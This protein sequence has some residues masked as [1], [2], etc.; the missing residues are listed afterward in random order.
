MAFIESISTLDRQPKDLGFDR[1][2]VFFSKYDKLPYFRPDRLA[3]ARC[4]LVCSPNNFL[5]EKKGEKK[6][7]SPIIGS[8]PEGA[9]QKLD[10]S[11]FSPAEVEDGTVRTAI[12]ANFKHW[13]TLEPEDYQAAK[14]EW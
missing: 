14:A 13:A 6:G 3:D 11:P 5:Y 8:G 2:T 10:L 7:I 1:A 12:P 9:S 4:G